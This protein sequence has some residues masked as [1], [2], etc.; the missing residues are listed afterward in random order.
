MFGGS[1]PR[2]YR[3]KLKYVP[4]SHDGTWKIRVD[5]YV[6]LEVKHI[7]HQDINKITSGYY[8]VV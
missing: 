5:G 1:D 7:E 6:S 8:A 2:Y 3:G 4:V